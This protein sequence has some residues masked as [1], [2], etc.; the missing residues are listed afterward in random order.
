MSWLMMVLM[1]V[2]VGIVVRIY[3]DIRKN[4]QKRVKDWDERLLEQLRAKGS[5]PFQPHEVDF[6]MAMPN[7]EAGR[8]VQ[9][10]LEADGFQVDMKPAPDNPNDQPFSLHATR[11]LRLSLPGLRDYRKRLTALATEH[12]GY[13]DGWSASFVPKTGGHPQP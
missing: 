1:L 3:M 9:A 11:L 6:F 2:A 13:Y 10:V 8:K 4:S 7:E 12:G 5:D